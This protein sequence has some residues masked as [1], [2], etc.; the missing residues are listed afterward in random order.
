MNT[1]AIIASLVLGSSSAAMAAPAVIYSAGTTVVRD[2]RGAEDDC[3]PTAGPVYSQPTAQPIYS[4]PVY[5]QPTAQPI[6]SGP[7]YSQPTAQPIYD[8]PVA[9]PSYGQ[10]SQP[11]W[12]GPIWRRPVAYRPLTLAAGAHFSGGRSFITNPDQ[13][14]LFGSL[15]LSAA[16]GRTFVDQVVVEF[17]NGQHQVIRDLNATLTGNQSVTLDLDGNRRGI[18]RIVVYGRDLRSGWRRASGGF[19]LTAV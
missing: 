11:V 9:E 15:Q 6:Y 16:G 18:R 10:I 8:E 19:T 3:A 13:R 12:S 1:K 5:S 4:G 17:D 14:R 7:V 2:Q